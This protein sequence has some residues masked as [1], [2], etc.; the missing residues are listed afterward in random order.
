MVTDA[1]PFRSVPVK[2]HRSP[3]SSAQVETVLSRCVAIFSALFGLQAIPAVIQQFDE[4]MPLWGMAVVTAF[5]AS[6]AVGLITSL[7]QRWVRPAQS[8]IAIVYL[9]AL[10]TWPLAVVHPAPAS[11]G[12]YWL[13]L[14]L[15]VAT[16]SAAIGLNTVIATTYLFVVPIIYGLIR[17]TPSGGGARWSQ[18]VLDSSYA[19]ILGGT[20][21]VIVTMLRY[22]ATSVDTA[23]ATA[24]DR[25]SHAVRQ[26]ATEVERVQVDSIVH[27]SVLTTLLSAARA[28]TP[29]AKQLSADMAASAIGHLREAALVVPDDGSTVRLTVLARRVTDAA[30]TLGR[31]FELRTRN[32]GSRS[33]PV[34]AAEAVF[35]AAM[36]AMVNSQQHAGGH[37]EVTRWLTIRGVPPT[38][39]EVEVGDTGAGFEIDEVPRERI[40]VRVSIVERLAN[41]GGTAAIVSRPGEGTVVTIR[42]PQDPRTTP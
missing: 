5:Y 26:H 34:L 32:V 11:A 4:T 7:L 36:Q 38:G 39:I 14:V 21:M 24:L 6:L 12:S 40:G 35:S 9:V 31:R 3:V 27:D 20:I 16:A 37:D 10:Q 2:P 42:W 22:A 23:Q 19:I 13:Y 25:Y 8:L 41:A 28:Y 17:L 15:T 30:N 29:E 33:I 18:V 1:T